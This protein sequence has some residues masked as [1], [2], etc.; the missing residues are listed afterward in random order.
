MP[1][2]VPATSHASRRDWASSSSFYAGCLDKKK[3]VPKNVFGD[4]GSNSENRLVHTEKR[5]LYRKQVKS[6]AHFRST[7]EIVSV[8]SKKHFLRAIRLGI[9]KVCPLGC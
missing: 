7:L 4:F 8:D 6:A 5:S 3:G 2:T 9:L 1:P